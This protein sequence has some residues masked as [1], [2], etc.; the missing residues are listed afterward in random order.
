MSLFSFG[1]RFEEAEELKNTG[2][3]EGMAHPLVDADEGEETAIFI[4][5]NVGTHQGAD[6]GRI[7]IRD[8]GEIDDERWRSFRAK[9]GLELKQRPQHDRSL[10]PENSLSGTSPVEIL[11]GKRFVR[12]RRHRGILAFRALEYGYN[13]VNS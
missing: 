5:R 8:G 1:R 3:F 12:D 9:S 2:Y 10:Q 13:H 7:D 11:D 6:S 4:V